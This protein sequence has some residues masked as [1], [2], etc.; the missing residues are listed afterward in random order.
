VPSALRLRPH[1]RFV[2]SQALI[3][4]A[5]ALLLGAAF[6]RAAVWAEHVRSPLLI[7]PLAVGSLLGL[8]LVGVMLFMNIGHRPTLIVGAALA[9]I[10]AAA[11]QHYFHYRDFIQARAESLEKNGGAGFLEQLKEVTPSAAPNFADYMRLQARLG[12]PI[13]AEYSLRDA[14]AWVSWAA[15]GLLLLA[16]AEAIVYLFARRPYCSGC[17][18]WYRTVRTGRMDSDTVMRLADAEVIQT[19]QYGRSMHYRLSHCASGCGPARLQ[20]AVADSNG[21]N[22]HC[23]AW[24][25]AAEREEVM[26]LLDTSIRTTA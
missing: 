21:G 4:I 9:A 20:L 16:A 25:S 11:G 19:P 13:T 12:R 6:A 10:V 2:V 22:Q 23:E 15:D 14:T 8:A 3:W 24:L 17:R 18:S 1:G 26:R 5:A 7:F